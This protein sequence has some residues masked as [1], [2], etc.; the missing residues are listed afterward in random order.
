[1]GCGGS[2]CIK[3]GIK[4]QSAGGYRGILR[5]QE[6]KNVMSG[7]GRTFWSHS[8]VAFLPN[9]IVFT[10]YTVIAKM[11]ENK[12]KKYPMFDVFLDSNKSPRTCQQ[13]PNR[14]PP[15]GRGRHKH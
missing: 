10:A 7:K 15:E 6:K 8:N 4:G 12:G 11:F 9:G 5:V 2:G 1:M 13:G 3:T 14:I